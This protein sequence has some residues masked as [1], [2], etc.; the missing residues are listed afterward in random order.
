[1]LPMTMM[2]T[3]LA[4]ALAACSA[5][6]PTMA[7]T[8]WG[9]LRAAHAATTRDGATPDAA[10][11]AA[12]LLVDPSSPYSE[13]APAPAFTNEVYWADVIGEGGVPEAAVL[14]HLHVELGLTR[15]RPGRDVAA[16]PGFR[17]PFVAAHATKAGL[18]ADIFWRM[19]DIHGYSRALHSAVPTLGLQLLREQ[20]LAIEPARWAALGVDVGVFQRVMRARH[21]DDISDHDLRYLDTLVQHRLL[22][23]LRGTGLPTAWRIARIAAA[24]RDAQGYVGGAPCRPDASPDR[25]FAGTLAAGDERTP[26]LVAAHDRAVHR[27]YVDALRR[28]P[29]ATERRGGALARVGVLVASVLPLVD[30]FAI[31]EVVEAAVADD[32]VSA[33]AMSR[34]DAEAAS[35]R[36]M[37]LACRIPE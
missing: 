19:L 37:R 17:D 4:M 16:K 6:A 29:P 18:D 3:T 26:C 15:A 21:E 22:H 27:W 34:A 28:P 7:S 5:A 1:M 30:M 25:R 23:P 9:R 31:A 14:G 2:R 11:Y 8:A 24:F 35:E 20:A 13:L 12:Q 33:E 36:A 10:A 32:L